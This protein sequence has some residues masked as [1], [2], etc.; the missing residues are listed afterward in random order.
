MTLEEIRLKFPR[1]NYAPR[2]NCKFC[3]GTGV[4]RVTLPCI[5]IFVSHDMCDFAAELLSETVKKIRDE[6]A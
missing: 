2:E 3:Q 6:H 4:R 1:A 5:C